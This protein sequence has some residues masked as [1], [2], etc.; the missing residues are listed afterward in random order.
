MIVEWIVIVL[1][2]VEVDSSDVVWFENM[3]RRVELEESTGPGVSGPLELGP[4]GSLG[5][6]SLDSLGSLGLLGAATGVVGK[7]SSDDDSWLEGRT[8]GMV[9][10][11]EYTSI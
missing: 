3:V 11:R 5:L 9:S 6:G 10:S 2:M 1:V 7:M 8:G 4:L